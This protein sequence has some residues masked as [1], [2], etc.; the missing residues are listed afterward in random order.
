MLDDLVRTPAAAAARLDHLAAVRV[1]AL[2]TIASR[3]C[4]RPSRR[5]EPILFLLEREFRRQGRV[6][7]GHLGDAVRRLVWEVEIRSMLSM[8][9]ACIGRTISRINISPKP[10][11]DLVFVRRCPRP[12]PKRSSPRSPVGAMVFRNRGTAGA[13]THVREEGNIPGRRPRRAHA[14]GLRQPRERD[15]AAGACHRA[16]RTGR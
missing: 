2:S 9:W 12:S 3:D 15:W 13:H 8:V 1:A 16:K 4:T 6:F 5:D 11:L 14:R 7:I 10:V